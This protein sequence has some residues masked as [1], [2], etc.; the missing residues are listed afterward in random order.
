MEI[1]P[2]QFVG[3]LA[4]ASIV[5]IVARVTNGRKLP[6]QFSLRALLTVM[7]LAA[8]ALSLIGFALRS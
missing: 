8:V 6:S 3:A 1:H 7:T 5:L 2:L 4:S